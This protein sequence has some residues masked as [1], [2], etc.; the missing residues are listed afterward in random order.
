MA[1]ATLWTTAL[2]LLQAAVLFLPLAIPGLRYPWFQKLAMGLLTLAIWRPRSS[3]VRARLPVALVGVLCTMASLL[4]EWVSGDHGSWTTEGLLYEMSL[5][6]LQEEPLYRGLLLDVWD[7]A[8]GRPWNA[9]SWKAICSNSRQRLSSI[10]VRHRRSRPPP[11][12][13]YASFPPVESSRS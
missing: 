12:P 6:G 1:V 8:T 10:R 5:P 2:L 13:A 7:K 9:L 4:D 11:L 3:P